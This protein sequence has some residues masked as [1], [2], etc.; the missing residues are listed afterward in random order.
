[1]DGKNQIPSNK[2]SLSGKVDS[3]QDQ[4][5]ASPTKI[6]SEESDA[7][8]R[9]VAELNETLKFAKAYNTI[10]RDASN[11]G[12]EL[13]EN[14]GSVL[15]KNLSRRLNSL[16]SVRS[17]DR[18]TVI[19]RTPSRSV[20][21]STPIDS[22]NPSPKPPS[23]HQ[24]P[25]LFIPQD[26]QLL[27]RS[28]INSEISSINS[29]VFEDSEPVPLEL[30]STK[31]PP[32][33]PPD[34]D[35]IRLTPE[36]QIMDAAEEEIVFRSQ[37]LA[38][39][40]EAYPPNGITDTDVEEKFF[41]AKLEEIDRV[42]EDLIG[43]ID[44][45]LYKFPQHGS[46]EYMEDLRKRSI[47]SVL[48]YKSLVNAQVSQVKKN[49]TSNSTASL[50]HER[51]EAESDLKRREVEAMERANTLT[52]SRI[53]EER[54]K[55]REKSVLKAKSIFNNVKEDVEKLGSQLTKIEIDEW[56]DEEDISVAKGMRN[57]DKW[58]G[59]LKEITTKLRELK[60]LRIVHDIQE[61]EVRCEFVENEVNEIEKVFNELKEKLEAED[62][63]RGLYSM[64]KP[65]QRRLIFLHFLE[66][67]SKT[68]ASFKQTWRMALKPTESARKSRFIS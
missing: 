63:G 33:A 46:K 3:G 38:Y 39:K 61:N 28:S 55:E 17:Q 41:H 12:L 2:N 47:E 30:S 24:T 60:D 35:V 52:E 65:K 19:T 53:A 26:S 9:L 15:Q 10:R 16:V 68:S 18:E 64:E 20:P 43:K 13:Q 1:M 66:K 4:E 21:T 42:Q 58:E 29:E 59:N 50:V 27:S 56:S 62:E 5:G 45:F 67:T 54:R 51:S 11:S 8:A 25:G 31:Q 57:L 32:I 48:N 37:T 7:A 14:L 40:L 34:R 23:K 6:V 36:D 44:K 49:M 22:A